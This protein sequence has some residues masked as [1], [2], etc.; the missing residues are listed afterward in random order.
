MK[1]LTIKDIINNGK[2][3][4]NSNK[5]I[6]IPWCQIFEIEEHFKKLNYKGKEFEHKV[7]EDIIRLQNAYYSQKVKEEKEIEVK[8]EVEVEEE[9]EVDVEVNVEVDDEEEVE[10]D[11]EVNVEVDVEEDVEVEVKEETKIIKKNKRN[12]HLHKK[13]KNKRNK[14]S[15]DNNEDIDKILEEIKKEDEIKN[16]N[17]KIE[18]MK[19]INSKI[20]E[21]GIDEMDVIE[22]NRDTSNQ[23]NKEFLF[24]LREQIITIE[25]EEEFEKDYNFKRA[26][27]ALILKNKDKINKIKII[28]KCEKI[29]FD[30]E[31]HYFR[32]FIKKTDQ[33]N[34][35]LDAALLISNMVLKIRETLEQSK[36]FFKRTA[37]MF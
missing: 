27:F 8:E 9:V 12:T 35:I 17:K 32:I 7:N 20:R 18:K 15:K 19:T 5:K 13:Q 36:I 33:Y 37:L 6:G 30:E 4:G 25:Y 2:N 1:Y 29:F 14:I 31:Q 26:L 28:T 24:H 21:T 10:V 23:L 22:E 3:L 16:K 11:V 34:K